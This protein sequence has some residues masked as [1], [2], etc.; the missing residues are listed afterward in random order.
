MGINDCA[1]KIMI[2]QWLQ[3]ALHLMME[4]DTRYS[5]NWFNKIPL[6]E[7]QNIAMWQKSTKEENST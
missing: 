6:A 2:N 1:V 7:T 4:S 3:T 5:C